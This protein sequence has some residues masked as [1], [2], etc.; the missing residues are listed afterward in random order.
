[1]NITCKSEC[2]AN[3]TI[4]SDHRQIYLENYLN[5]IHKN[6]FITIIT[7]TIYSILIH[8]EI[9]LNTH[10]CKCMKQK[11]TQIN[12]QELNKKRIKS[13]I[14]GLLLIPKVQYSFIFIPRLLQAF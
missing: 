5:S 13:V 2:K 9:Y 4:D 14:P 12:A 6:K 8:L 7:K 11:E 1:M 10:C 3:F